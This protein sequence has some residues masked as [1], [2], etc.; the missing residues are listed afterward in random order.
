MLDPMFENVSAPLVPY[1]TD[2]LR[3][4]GFKV[5]LDSYSANEP[6][7]MGDDEDLLYLRVGKNVRVRFSGGYCTMMVTSDCGINMPVRQREEL[8]MVMADLRSLI[9]AQP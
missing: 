2:L 8:E 3:R 1:L 4:N 6:P 5:D 7:V 9:I